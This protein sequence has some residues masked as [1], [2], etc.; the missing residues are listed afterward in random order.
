MQAQQQSHAFNTQ[1]TN[2][3]M[4]TSLLDNCFKDC[5]TD[6]GKGELAEAEDKCL[7]ECTRRDLT[8]LNHGMMNF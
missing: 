3:R 1:Y 8:L 5:V 2:M 7:K 4:G 6:F